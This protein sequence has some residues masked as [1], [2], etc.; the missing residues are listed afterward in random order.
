MILITL[1]TTRA[2]RLKTYGYDDGLTEELARYSLNGVVFD[3]AYA[4][5]PI[6]LPSHTT[7]LTGLYPPEHGLRFNGQ[8]KAGK[9]RSPCFPRDS[10]TGIRD[11][12]PGHLFLLR[13]SIQLSGLDRGFDVYEDFASQRKTKK[14]ARQ[15]R[16]G[17]DVV[18]SALTWLTSQTDKPFFCWIHLFDVHCSL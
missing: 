2:D 14:L 13:F 7:M 8:G 18:D 11:I 15:R 17:Q 4:P 12:K 6:T 3:R 1:D 16:P 9:N 10:S 5:A